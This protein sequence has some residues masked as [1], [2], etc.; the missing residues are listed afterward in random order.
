M[1]DQLRAFSA[2]QGIT[3]FGYRLLT[4]WMWFPVGWF[5]LARFRRLTRA[6]PRSAT[7]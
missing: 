1:H 4:F 6:A 3:I 7:P 2:E 5:A